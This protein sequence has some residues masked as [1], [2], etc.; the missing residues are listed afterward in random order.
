MANKVC[1]KG[2][3]TTTGHSVEKVLPERDIMFSASFFKAG[4][5]V[6]AATANVVTCRAADLAFL[7]ILSDVSLTQVVM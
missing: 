3:L 5:G 2:N 1:E 7:D 4:K 6:S